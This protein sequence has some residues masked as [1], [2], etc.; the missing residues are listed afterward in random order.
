VHDLCYRCG[1]R[2]DQTIKVALQDFTGWYCVK[3]IQAMLIEFDV[4]I[5]DERSL[6]IRQHE[7][8]EQ[9]ERENKELK[10]E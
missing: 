7:R 2:N 10:E 8:I 3:C 6:I 9:L 5:K 1:D 4:R